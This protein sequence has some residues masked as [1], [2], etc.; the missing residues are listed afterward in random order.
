MERRDFD[1][2]DLAFGLNRPDCQYMSSIGMAGQGANE[3]VSNGHI[4]I[5]DDGPNTFTFTNQAK[6]PLVLVLW[7]FLP[8]GYQ[9]AFM[10]V[11]RPKVSYSLHNRDEVTVSVANGVSGGWSTLVNSETRLTQHGLIDNTWG[12]FTTG[13]HATVDIS[14][15]VNM[16]GTG[17]AVR[18]SGD[19]TSDMD[20]CVFVC[21]SGT[22]C[23]ESGTYELLNCQPG[24]QP[25]A[26]YGTFANA[27]SGGCQGWSNGGRLQVTLGS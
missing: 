12:E 9:A 4:W 16:S 24:S 5:G 22:T 3:N 6:V 13:E 21:R 15:E 7:D 19:C 27:A 8:N 26:A 20:T 17:I 11:R 2:S 1:C 25:G 23:G 14:R 18:T 10:N